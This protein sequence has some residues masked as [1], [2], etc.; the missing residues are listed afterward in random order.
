MNS[1]SG[2]AFVLEDL[3]RL[4]R[5]KIFNNIVKKSRYPLIAEKHLDFQRIIVKNQKTINNSSFSL[6]YFNMFNI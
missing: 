6:L 2:T 3:K 5:P 4:K 1:N